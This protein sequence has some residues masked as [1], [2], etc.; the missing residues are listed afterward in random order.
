MTRFAAFTVLMFALGC[1]SSPS[2]T[3]QM[4][5]AAA[6]GTVALDDMSLVVP[7]S[8]L[9]VDT[10]ISLRTEALGNFAPL[11]GAAD[12]V[13]TIAPAETA[14]ERPGTLTLDLGG[15]IAAG[16]RAGV[17]H[18]VDGG[19]SQV[20]SAVVSGGLLRAS[21]T[22]LGTYAVTRKLVDDTGNR[23]TGALTWSDT[24]AARDIPIQ[25]QRDGAV[26]RQ[27]TTDATGGFGFVDLEPGTY[28]LVVS[29]ECALDRTVIVNPDAPTQLSLV[30]CGAS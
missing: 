1:S 9:A 15:A 11:A 10:E 25:L 19:W 28:Q 12:E 29:S 7:P 23:I 14:L 2:E 24:S 22:Y 13:L 21:V 5:T 20:E 3:S 17:Y 6:G 30:L 27:T 8:A 16:E 18:F 26:V 4:I